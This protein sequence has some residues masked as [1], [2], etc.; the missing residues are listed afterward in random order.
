MT[1]QE[2]I[3]FWSLRITILMFFLYFFL[4]SLDLMGTSFKILGG[5]TAGAMFGGIN[6]PIAGLM[7]GILATV[8]VQSSSTSTSI[9]VSLV[10]SNAMAV[11]VAIPVIMGANIG[12]SV[13]N[14]IVALGQVTDADQF[15]RAFAGATVHD[16]FN[17]MSVSV[18]LLIELIAHPLYH[19]SYGCIQTISVRDDD[20]W[21]GPI[22]KLVA[23]LVEKFL[24]ANKNVIKEV[25]GGDATCDDFYSDPDEYGL[26]NCDDDF[27]P[28]HCPLFYDAS[29]AKED[30]LVA[31]G[32]CL[33]LSLLLLCL[34]LSGLVT[35]LKSMVMA[36]SEEWIRKATDINPYL[37]MVV[38]MGVTILVQ[39][40]SITTS[41]LTPLAGLGVISVEQMYPL[42]LGANVGT[43]GTALLAS[44]VSD[45]VEAVQIALCHLFFNLFGILLFF[46]IP[47]MRNLP[48][49]AAKELGSMTRKWKSTPLLYILVAFVICPGILLGVSSLFTQNN[50]A[51]TVVGVIIT[52]A[53]TFWGGYS[54]YYWR[55][56]DGKKAFFAWL[57][58]RQEL[59]DIMD[60][61]VPHGWRQLVKDVEE[62]KGLMKDVAPTLSLVVN[63]PT[64]TP[65]LVKADTTLEKEDEK[66]Q[67]QPKL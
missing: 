21:E 7:V 62:L 13:T 2:K 18:L 19:I 25:A 26:I 3:L 44:L 27:D 32:V 51:Y 20:K 9:V 4:F 37:A 41:V 43:T 35:V 56:K 47:Y 12:T 1:Q 59:S 48:I 14:T 23:P 52:M 10:G 33:F 22:K 15:E 31:G 58:K 39:S 61:E 17:F 53:L 42:T 64:D 28:P 49:A 60:T 54:V 16:M 63:A 67:E 24:K 29:N 34:C 66:Q 6:N 40:S 38:G 57:E 8:M 45:K 5:C 50:P 65:A 30:D 55:Y 46:P 11:Q 36:S